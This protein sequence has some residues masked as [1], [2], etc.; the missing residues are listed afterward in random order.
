M[1]VLL[2]QNSM[3]SPMSDHWKL[4]SPEMITH[5]NGEGPKRSPW[6]QSL[7]FTVRDSYL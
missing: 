1:Y 2:V 6:S 4:P 7:P 3:R 5:A